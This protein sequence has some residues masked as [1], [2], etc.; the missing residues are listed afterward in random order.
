M[1]QRRPILLILSSHVFLLIRSF[2]KDFPTKILYA[3]LSSI[4][5]SYILLAYFPKNVSE[6]YEIVILSVRLCVPR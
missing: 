4:D 2:S 3:I 5:I 1:D 6:A